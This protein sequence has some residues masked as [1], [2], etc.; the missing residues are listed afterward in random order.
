VQGLELS[1]RFYAAAVR[2]ILEQHFAGVD[3]AAALVGWSS[4]VLGFDDE[5]SRD[6]QWGPRLQLYVRKAEGADEIEQFLAREL[7]T[8]F[9][10][11]PTNFGPTDEPGMVR[12]AAAE[13]GPIAHRVEVLVLRSELQKWLGLDPL[14]GFT[15][16]DWLVTPSQRLLEWTAGDVFHDGIGE[17]TRVRELFAWYPHDVWLFVMAGHWQ[18][19][20][21]FEHLHGRT[22]LRGDE[23]GSRLLAAALVR[24]VM[25]LRLLQRRRYPPYPKWLGTAY[26]ELGCPERP[27]LEAALRADEWRSREDALVEALEAVARAHNELG[28]TESVDPAT[29][30]FWGRP[31]RVLFA[32]RFATALR[33]AITDPALRAIDHRAGSVDAVSDNTKLLTVPR[34]WQELRGLY[35]RP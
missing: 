2:P 30:R 12:M 9:L 29:R 24:D 31:I 25:R 3:H 1:R 28:V 26:A 33:E 15:V 17:L 34:L 5:M 27:A 20:A 19:I 11:F 6:H 14:A 4:E 23:L 21:E 13:V 32:D 7:P 10:G 18:R 8:T 22:G 35:D 16:A